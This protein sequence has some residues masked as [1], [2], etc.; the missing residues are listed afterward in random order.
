MKLEA[1]VLSGGR[2]SRMGRDKAGIRID[3]STLIERIA[4]ELRNLN[5][6]VTI[7]G[8]QNIQGT[9]QIHDPEPHP[10]PLVALAGFQP[11]SDYVFVCSCDLVRFDPKTVAFLETRIDE[12]DAAVPVVAGYPQPLCALYRAEAFTKIDPSGRKSMMSWLDVLNWT[13]VN[14][15]ELTNNG[16]DARTTLGVNTPEEL[17]AA[18][19]Q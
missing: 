19:A 12:K 2:S 1:V 16:I 9:I 4:S 17:A 15:T 10:G 11:Q 7:L 6:Q 3:G 13:P 18:L 8:P 14:E 5:L